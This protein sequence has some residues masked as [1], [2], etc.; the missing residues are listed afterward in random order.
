MYYSKMINGFIP[1]EWM[2]DGTYN[3]APSDAIK[4]KEQEIDEFH[5]ISIPGKMID[6]SNGRLMWVDLPPPTHEELVAAAGTENQKRID[7]ANEYMNSKQWPGKAAMGRL[8]EEDKT[9]Y[10]LWLD[11]LEELEVVDISFAPDITWPVQPS[12]N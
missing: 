6:V 8:S 12:V 10:N 4:L 1:D 11:Y 5:G 7:L 2:E 9:Q 3:P